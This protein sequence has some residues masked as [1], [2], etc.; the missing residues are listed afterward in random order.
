MTNVA[1]ARGVP[2]AQKDPVLKRYP[3]RRLRLPVGSGQL[4]VVVPD[5]RAWMRKGTWAAEVLRGKEP[6]YWCRIW[7]AAVSIARQLV[8]S[9]SDG[10]EAPL[11]GVRVLDLGCG[12]G[13]PGIQAAQLGAE[14][15]SVDVES[16]ALA[17]AH[18]N[19]RMQPGCLIAPTKQQ[20]DW[21]VA[22]VA[23]KFDLVLLSDV[24]YH[25]DHHGP[26]CQQ[27]SRVLA[28]GGC[29][30]HADPGRDASTLFLGGLGRDYQRHEW[31]RHTQF[32]DLQADIRLT[33]LARTSES[34]VRWIER[35]AVPSDRVDM[36]AALSPTASASSSP[37]E[38]PESMSPSQAE[39]VKSEG[40]MSS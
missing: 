3:L 16:D 33:M 32:L 17:F 31:Q 14:V 25:K 29:V 22:N 4:S 36:G 8:R 26:I 9:R 19:A 35:L 27:L 24:T 12:V 2:E 40:T 18:W 39:M 23:G 21:S 13:V 11:A 20:V 15:C 7:P 5:D 28:D 1:Q 6:P 30:L 10:E 34:L 38:L 37:V